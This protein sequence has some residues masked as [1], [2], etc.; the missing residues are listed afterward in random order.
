MHVEPEDTYAEHRR[1]FDDV[2][3]FAR[4]LIGERAVEERDAVGEI[5]SFA[6]LN[7]RARALCLIFDQWLVVEAGDCGGRWE[8]DYTT[9]KLALARDIV[10]SVV[11][12]RIDERFAFARSRVTVFLEDGSS[13]SETGYNGCLALVVPQPGWTAWGERRAYEPY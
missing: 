4:D 2:V 1:L 13:V 8:L 10:S 7:E 12:G 3:G 5:I 11:A 9:D 6:P